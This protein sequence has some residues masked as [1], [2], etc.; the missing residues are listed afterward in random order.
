MTKHNNNKKIHKIFVCEKCEYNTTNKKDY[1][2]HLQTKKHNDKHN[3]TYTETQTLYHCECGKVYKYLSGLSRHK[4]K[5]NYTEIEESS[6]Y[7]AEE[8]IEDEDKK[9]MKLLLMELIKSN[10]DVQEKLVE[11]AKQPKTVNNTFNLNNFLNVQCK[12]A[13]NLSEFLDSITLRFEDL[14]YLS[15]H[16]FVDS[17]QDTFIKN[18]ATLDQHIRP[19]HCTDQKRKNFVVKEDDRWHKKD[20]EGLICDAFHSMNKK[21]YNAFYIH[22]KERPDDYLDNMNNTFLN[23]NMIIGMTQYSNTKKDQIDSK[24]ISILSKKTPINK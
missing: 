19:I 23:S 10:K 17:I 2:K 3:I 20:S 7:N 12:D 4:K 13:M 9:D 15:N 18:L 16:G 14:V 6:S 24:L 5:C 11:I 8:Y 21:Q 1:N 22:S